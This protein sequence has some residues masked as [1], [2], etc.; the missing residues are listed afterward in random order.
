[1]SLAYA[2]LTFT[3]GKAEEVSADSFSR[4]KVSS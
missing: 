3:K 1:M 4:T 2:I